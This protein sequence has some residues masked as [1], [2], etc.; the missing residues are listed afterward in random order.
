MGVQGGSYVE[1]GYTQVVFANIMGSK[2][3]NCP[4]FTVVV[5]GYHEYNSACGHDGREEY[6]DHSSFKHSLDWFKGTFTGTPPYFM[7][8]SK[9][10]SRFSLKPSLLE[11]PGIGYE[12]PPFRVRLG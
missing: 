3:C 10:S 11:T 7:G 6:S 9:V 4:N 5:L 1:Y 12:L 2:T 8:K